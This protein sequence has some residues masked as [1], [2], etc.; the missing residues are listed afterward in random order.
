MKY[1]FFNADELW[2][3][4]KNNFSHDSPK[5]NLKAQTKVFIWSCFPT[6]YM[7]VQ[8][9][10][11]KRSCSSLQYLNSPA[12]VSA[13]S[14]PDWAWCSAKVALVLNHRGPRCQSWSSV[15][16]L[17]P[18]SVSPS[19][20]RSSPAG[21]FPSVCPSVVWRMPHGRFSEYLPGRLRQ[22]LIRRHR[23]LTLWCHRCC[24]CQNPRFLPRCSC[25]PCWP[26]LWTGV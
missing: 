15:H 2:W 12:G 22:R 21:P 3:T 25:R 4:V 5:L 23:A 8:S 1:F 14:Q 19:G 20:G 17:S 6:S 13:S 18:P 9:T 16:P 11:H 7:D 26:G 10:S 24:C